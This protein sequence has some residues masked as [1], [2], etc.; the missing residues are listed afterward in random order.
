MSSSVTKK[1]NK[2]QAFSSFAYFF[3]LS[4]VSYH[5]SVF[6]LGQVLVDIPVLALN[7]LVFGSCFYWLS[8]LQRDAGKQE[9]EVKKKQKRT[10]AKK[11]KKKEAR[12]TSQGLMTSSLLITK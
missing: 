4:V 2:N 9:Q 6:V 12:R 1:K 8:G 3:F 10:R 5:S 7:M 11:T